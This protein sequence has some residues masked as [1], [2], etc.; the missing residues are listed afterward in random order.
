MSNHTK[1]NECI[2]SKDIN[3]E[4]SLNE[5]EIV[6]QLGTGAANHCCIQCLSITCEV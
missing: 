1:K 3:G 5:M 4:T 2:A 6:H